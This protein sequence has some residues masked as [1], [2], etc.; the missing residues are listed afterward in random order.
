MTQERKKLTFEDLISIYFKNFTKIIFTNILFA[1][2]F[3]LVGGILYFLTKDADSLVTAFVVPMCILI[4]Y[5]LNAGVTKVTRNIARGDT[6]TEVFKLFADAVLNNFRQFIIHGL[7]LYLFVAI[8]A[9]TFSFYYSS[10]MVM[11]GVMIILL[12]AAVLIALVVLMM[13]FYIPLMTVTYDLSVKDIYKNSVLMA[14]GEIKVNLA[15]LFAILILTAVCTTP[16][17]IL[18]GIKWLSL[19]FA[20][21]VFLLIYPASCT[22]AST[23][24]VNRNMVLLLSG[25]G[26]KVHSTKNAEERLAKLRQSR[27]NELEGLDI[28]KLRQS[29]EEYIFHNGKMMKRS[30]VLSQL[31]KKADAERNME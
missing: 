25:E 19:G 12:I 21:L 15:A 5:P 3:V 26:D 13:F 1:L 11:G 18:G 2:P 14:I 27:E 23:Y 29:K 6:V 10:A 22:Y 9:F 16:V 20:L 17:M 4:C 24:L 31:E 30:A 28:E 7:F 8:G